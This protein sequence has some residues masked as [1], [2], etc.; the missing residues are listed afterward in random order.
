M[1][2]GSG[3]A[4]ALARAR[5]SNNPGPRQRFALYSDQMTSS[6]EGDPARANAPETST[7]PTPSTAPALSPRT[8]R[9]VTRTG[10]A[11][12]GVLH[13]IVGVIALLIPLTALV[14]PGVERVGAL[15][16]VSSN[17]GGAVLF[18]VVAI[19]YLLLGAWMLS[20]LLLDRSSERRPRD[21]AI[22]IGRCIA[23]LALGVV[24]G[25]IALAGRT[26]PGDDPGSL[27]ATPLQLPP[28][29]FAPV[30]LIALAVA[31][32]YALKGWRRGYLD[33]IRVP[34][35]SSGRRPTI[36]AGRIAYFGKALA[37][38]I[39]GVLLIVGALL[40]P[41]EAGVG[42]HLA[43]LALT[44]AGPLVLAV[45]GLGLIAYGFYCGARARLARL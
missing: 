23:Y 14:T 24:A 18:W 34:Q 2:I 19:G 16:A 45:I 17:P 43:S 41:G 25:G 44:P 9:I 30:G 20:T 5:P 11:V 40:P 35:R 7:E 21:R 31:V 15:R 4:S 29:L 36:L 8:V 39:I 28:L 12:N 33:D 3:R 42:G 26:R 1:T 32:Y 27:I 38:G 22:T 10:L 37:L 13:V 6:T